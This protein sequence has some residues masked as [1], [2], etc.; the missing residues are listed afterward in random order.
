MD[1]TGKIVLVRMATGQQR[2]TMARALLAKG[3][4]REAHFPLIS[5]ASE[6][7]RLGVNMS[8]NTM[9]AVQFHTYGGP[10]QLIVEHVTRPEPQAGEALV[11]VFAAGVNPIDWKIRKG[12]FKNVMPLAL[13]CTPGREFAGTIEQLGPGVTTFQPG[14][15]VY[16]REGKGTYAEYA[17]AAADTL[18]HKPRTISFDQAASV[19]VGARTAW[20]ALFPSGGKS[21]IRGHQSVDSSGLPGR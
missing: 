12:L 2:G 11:R 10:E 17:I 8:Q 5:V 18:M 21:G 20:M 13:P 6:G 7:I 4:S 15:A 16:G 19:P 3:G 9:R 1:R 14:Q